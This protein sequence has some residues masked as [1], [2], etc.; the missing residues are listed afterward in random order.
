MPEFI[1][2]LPVH[3]LV[4]HAVVVLIP[5]AVLGAIVIAVW[6]AARRR[7]GWIVVGFAAVGTILTPIATDSGES[8]ERRLPESDL[9]KAHSELGDLLIWFALGLLIAVAALMV[10]ETIP[11]RAWT[12][13]AV[14]ALAVLSIA[15][16]VAAGVHVYRVGDAGAKAVWNGIDQQPERTGGDGD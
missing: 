1:N 4:V 15:T 2:G 6:P 16:G 7:I 14:I 10:V 5:L 13:P 11:A 8:L 12:K 3:A 9:I